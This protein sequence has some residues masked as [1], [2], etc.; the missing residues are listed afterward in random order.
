M[1][2]KKRDEKNRWRNRTI[3]FRLS[4]EEEIELNERV[5]LMGYQIKQDYIVEAVLHNEV[6]AVGNPLMM[7]QFRRSLQNIETELTRITDASQIGKDLLDP[8]RTMLQIMEAFEKGVSVDQ[9]RIVQRKLELERSV[10]EH[11][12]VPRES[13]ARGR[14]I[15]IENQN[16]E[17]A[18]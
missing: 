6:Y 2:Q 4:P 10:H 8:I 5:K 1:S 7:L 16:K 9:S 3:A 17:D 18:F 15:D 11:R 14:H 13:D 12:M